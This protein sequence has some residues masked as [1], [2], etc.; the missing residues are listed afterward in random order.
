MVFADKKR[1]IESICLHYSILSSLTELEQLKEGLAIQKFSTLMM[2]VPVIIRTAFTQCA[3]TVTSSVIEELYC[4]HVITAPRGSDKWNRQLAILGAWKCYLRG[5]EGI[6]MG[7]FKL[8]MYVA[9]NS[10]HM[11]IH[12]NI[13]EIMFEFN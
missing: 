1:I 5:I 8:R 10:G 2:K 6:L 13:L 12:V 4:D 7:I 11:I 9:T 3:L